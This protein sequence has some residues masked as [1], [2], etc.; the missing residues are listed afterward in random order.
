[1]PHKG[2]LRRHERVLQGA[3]VQVSWKD[4]LGNEK[5]ANA[6]ILDV[7]EAGIRVKVPESL[8]EHTLVT[9]RSDRLALHGRA[10]VRSCDRQ[11]AKYLVGLE[12]IGG[13]SWKPPSEK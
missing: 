13:L 11:G 8:A 7:S 12:F 3:P 4:R 10:S 2:D 1:M 9:L 6:E 5:F